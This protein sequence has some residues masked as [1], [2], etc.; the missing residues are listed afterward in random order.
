MMNKQV[1]TG[2]TIS[3]RGGESDRRVFGET[4]GVVE[5]WIDFAEVLLWRVVAGLAVLDIFWMSVCHL[6]IARTNGASNAT[7]ATNPAISVIVLAIAI[8]FLRLLRRSRHE[9]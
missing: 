1:A 7:V 2:K 8:R 4:S 3:R 9:G 5:V 6:L